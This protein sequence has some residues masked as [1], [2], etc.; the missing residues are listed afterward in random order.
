MKH[1]FYTYIAQKTPGDTIYGMARVDS[2]DVFP[3]RFVMKSFAD[4]P[5]VPPKNACILSFQ[6]ID[7]GTND[8][9]SLYFKETP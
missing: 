2:T 6:E 7:P 4:S 9:I 3:F 1:W 8:E 5:G